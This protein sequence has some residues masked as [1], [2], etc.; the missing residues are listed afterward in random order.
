MNEDARETTRA[1]RPPGAEERCLTGA[2]IGA[3]AVVLAPIAAKITGHLLDRPPKQE[4][5][6]VEPVTGYRPKED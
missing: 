4:P 2:L 3:G 6:K 5:A 1:E